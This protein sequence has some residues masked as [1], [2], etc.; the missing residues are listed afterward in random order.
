MTDRCRSLRI[1]RW[2]VVRCWGTRGHT[3]F[4]KYHCAGL[5]TGNIWLVRSR[6]RNAHD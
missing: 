4:T 1:R 6:E 5:S 2:R 3:A